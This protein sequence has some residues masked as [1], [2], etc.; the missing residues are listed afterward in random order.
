M[1]IEISEKFSKE[2]IKR[3]NLPSKENIIAKESEITTL[4]VQPI[5]VNTKK[6]DYTFDGVY[7]ENI[8]KIAAF[9]PITNLK[10]AIK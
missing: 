8:E 9:P 7:F 1:F 2:S 10:N 5:K 6:D 4:N 3:L